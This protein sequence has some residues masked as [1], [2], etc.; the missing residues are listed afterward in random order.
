MLRITC[1]H[2]SRLLSQQEDAPLP[3][4]KR[5]RLRLH[6]AV[7]DAC[8]NVSRQFATIRL[9]LQGWRERD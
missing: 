5:L 6:L 2:A 1:Q 4:G 8:R 7:C 9:A 3:F